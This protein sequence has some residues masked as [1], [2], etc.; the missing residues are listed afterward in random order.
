[1]NESLLKC[2]LLFIILRIVSNLPKKN[3]EGTVFIAHKNAVEALIA[4]FKTAWN[5]AGAYVE[6]AGR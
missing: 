6:N 1:M 3:L 4:K 5:I 2:N